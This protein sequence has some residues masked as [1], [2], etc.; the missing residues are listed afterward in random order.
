MINNDDSRITEDKEDESG[1]VGSERASPPIIHMHTHRHFIYPG[2]KLKN[3]GILNS[4]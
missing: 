2:D 3:Q 4:I 1:Q